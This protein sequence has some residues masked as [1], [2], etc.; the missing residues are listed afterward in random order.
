MVAMDANVQSFVVADPVMK[1]LGRPDCKIN[2]SG[3][4]APTENEGIILVLVKVK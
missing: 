1:F 4:L 3:K 2:M